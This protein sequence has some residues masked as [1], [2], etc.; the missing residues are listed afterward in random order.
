[1][2][3]IYEEEL[4]DGDGGCK[5]GR[6]IVMGDEGIMLYAHCAYDCGLEV[7]AKT[8]DKLKEKVARYK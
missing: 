3:D 6:W 1:M 8:K 4:F 7:R 5:H 2:T